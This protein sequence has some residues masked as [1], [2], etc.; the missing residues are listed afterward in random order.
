MNMQTAPYRHTKIIAT[1]GPAVNKPEVFQKLLAHGVDIIRLNMA[2][3]ND[4]WVREVT[5]MIRRE[6]EAAKR[7]VAIMMD[8]KGPEIRTG[9]VPE[10]Y[11]L[12][13]G[14]VFDFFTSEEAQK[15]GA[16]EGIRHTTVNYPNLPKDVKKGDTL[17]VDSGLIRMEVLETTPERIRA[18]VTIPGE[19]GKRRHI[20][21]PGIK[22]NLPSLTEKDKKDIRLGIECGVHF[23]ALSFV[24][25]ASDIEVMRWYMKEQGSNAHIIAKIEDQ[26]AVENLM[27]IIAASDG[28]MVARGDLGIEVPFEKLP[29]IQ[30]TA[31]QACQTAGKPVI[32]ATHMLESMIQSP[33]PTRAEI[34]DVANAVLEH[35]DCVMLSGETS[36]GKYPVECV[37]VLNRIIRQIEGTPMEPPR[38][39]RPKSPKTKMMV[40]AAHLA[41]DLGSAG[42]VVFTRSGDL[43]RGLSACRQR[44]S[45]IFAFTDN[46]TTFFEL[47]IVWGVEPFYMPFSDDMDQTVQNAINTLKERGWSKA[48]DLLV[49][50]SSMPSLQPT[51]TVEVDTV[52]LRWVK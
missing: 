29:I 21:L 28:L 9:D 3:A 36:V 40:A 5:A 46:R 24:R 25:E 7:H 18:K 38:F 14:E 6:C 30:R 48:E 26:C 49:V 17:L 39:F 33:M 12:M 13:E 47:L 32:V 1:F 43:A 16:E 37:N 23:Y 31:V 20:N 45:P 34:S 52:Q 19:M 50:A 51:G 15:N 27:E 41:N 10:T 2:H 35:A 11:K 44:K 22:V 42:I 8:V 4:E